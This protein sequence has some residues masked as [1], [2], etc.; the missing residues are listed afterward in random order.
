MK[1]AEIH[2]RILLSRIDGV[3]ARTFQKILSKNPSL[4]TFLKRG[5]YRNVRFLKNKQIA[6]ITKRFKD[7]W[8]AHHLEDI[9]KY[10]I[11]YTVF[12]MDS[13]PPRLK[14]IYDPP[15]LLYYKGDLGIACSSRCLAIVGTRKM[16]AYG[17][18]V[19]THL[20]TELA[21]HNWVIV[22]GMAFGIDCTA[23]QAVLDV[24]GKTIA[25]LA[26]SVHT[27]S[28]PR[29]NALY[30][31]VVKSGLVISEYPPGDEIYA[32]NF[33]QRNR[34]IAGLADG[35]VVI[36][37]GKK[38][39]AL[40]TASFALEGGREVFA[41]PGSIYS[42]Q[43]TGTHQLIQKGEAK[44][45]HDLGDILNEFPHTHHLK[46]KSTVILTDLEKQLT[47]L[48]LSEPRSVDQ[49]IES[50]SMPVEKL[51]SLLTKMEL[52][53]KVTKDLLGKYYSNI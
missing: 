49:I 50:I 28:P 1:T 9:A 53:G 45:I 7:D 36:E 5:E 42:P 14:N 39:G 26:G 16:S 34:I 17:Q 20:A 31:Q 29:N 27:S 35:V 33:I 11:S 30:K 8:V 3:G 21:Q 32:S 41:L 19:A 13:Y 22:S 25:V 40:S 52:E 46:T 2:A 12:G 38:S 51:L 47:N 37:A 44:L 48:V 10:S 15:A 18:R 43:S 23:Q 24:S 6:M 4:Y